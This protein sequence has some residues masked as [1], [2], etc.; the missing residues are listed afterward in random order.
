MSLLTARA[1]LAGMA[2]EAGMGPV[3]GRLNH[4]VAD[5]RDSI[6]LTQII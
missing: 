3:I 5:L 1:A 4:T 6:V 2:S